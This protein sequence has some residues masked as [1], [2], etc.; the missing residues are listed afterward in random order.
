M[1]GGK[2]PDNGFKDNGYYIPLGTPFSST[3]TEVDSLRASLVEQLV[4]EL[5]DERSARFYR[6]VVRRVPHPLVHRVLSETRAARL[7]GRLE[8]P[9]GAYFTAVITR[10]ARELG[11]HLRGMR[12][13]PTPTS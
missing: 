10:E 12:P 9:P 7:E 5:G 1:K 6:L 8:R 13:K 11:I 4:E 2:S 3:T